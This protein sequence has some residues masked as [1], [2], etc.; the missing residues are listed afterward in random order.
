MSTTRFAIFALAAACSSKKSAP[1][2]A[3]PCLPGEISSAGNGIA[4][5]DG[6]T[7]HA[8]WGERCLTLDRDGKATGLADPSATQ[9]AHRATDDAMT[10]DVRRGDDARVTVCNRVG[11]GT[12]VELAVPPTLAAESR[13]VAAS[14]S[15]KRLTVFFKDRLDT[16]DLKTKAVISSFP[17]TLDVLDA[18]YVGDTR[19]L[20]RG[21]GNDPWVLHDLVGGTTLTVGEPDRD[22]TVIDAKT[23]VVF[24][25]ARLTVINAAGM[26][27]GASF[28]MPGRVAMA[29]AWFDR[30]LVVLDHPAG[31]AQIDP[32]TGTL[33]SGPALPLCK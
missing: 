11:T 16:W 19:V 32:A 8:C 12:C 27:I 4:A 22:L 1:P 30:I 24:H 5:V 21:A 31:T 29:T 28:T 14:T 18:R 20:A 25:D 15:L 2:P 23:A 6:I 7:A 13:A 3:A 33:Y 26:S 9:A 10:T 17:T